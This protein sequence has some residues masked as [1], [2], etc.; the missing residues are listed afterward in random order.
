MYCLGIQSKVAEAS[1][2]LNWSPGFCV[3]YGEPET[4][5]APLIGGSSVS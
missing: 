4:A 1:Q 3:K 5:S 2:A